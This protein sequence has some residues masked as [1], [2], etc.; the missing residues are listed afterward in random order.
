MKGYCIVDHN[1]CKRR[2]DI[3]PKDRDPKKPYSIG[4][5]IPVKPR[6]ETTPSPC[7]ISTPERLPL[8]IKASRAI[9]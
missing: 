7:L 4:R 6:Y 2:N 5:H 1:A 8:T 9:V 3:L